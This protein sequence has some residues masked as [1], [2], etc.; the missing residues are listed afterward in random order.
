MW[1]RNFGRGAIYKILGHTLLENAA[2]GE[3]EP[4]K[5]LISDRLLF[6]TFLTACSLVS[7]KFQEP[8]QLRGSF[9]GKWGGWLC[10]SC[11]QSG[12]A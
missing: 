4:D 8:L 10:V 12:C 5:N 7:S 9:G 6:L 3:I 2:A 11:D 1:N